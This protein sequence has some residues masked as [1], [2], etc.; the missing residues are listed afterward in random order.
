MGSRITQEKTLMWPIIQFVIVVRSK[1]RET[2][3]AKGFQE[4]VIRKYVEKYMI[5][6][7]EIQWDCG[8]SVYKVNSSCESK[9]PKLKR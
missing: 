1:Q 8:K 9:V 3:T 7:W 5:R 2:R 6:H 4:V